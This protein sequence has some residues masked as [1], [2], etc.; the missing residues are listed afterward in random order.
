MK[1]LLRISDLSKNEQRV[2]LI[3]ILA[4]IAAALVRYERR[5]HRHAV[6]PI[7]AMEAKA[8]PTPAQTEDEQ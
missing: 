7:S 6:Q 2:I 8:S 5:V 1:R 4:L 3:V